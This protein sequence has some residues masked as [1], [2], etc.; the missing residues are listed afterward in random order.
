MIAA[1]SSSLIAYFD[2][3]TGADVDAIDDALESTRLFLPPVV[4]TELASARE[5]GALAALPL[6]AVESGYWQ[7]AGKLRASVLAKGFKA[8]LA[9]ALI[10]QSCIDARMALITR[11]RDFRHYARAGLRIA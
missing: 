7:R 2:G 3:E 8:R 6:L 10:A 4:L 1:D 11:D 9:D 5:L